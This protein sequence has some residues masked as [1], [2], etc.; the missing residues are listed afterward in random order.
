VSVIIRTCN[1]P[2]LLKRAVDSAMAQV[3]ANIEIVVIDDGLYKA[4]QDFAQDATGAFPVQY[5]C[6]CQLGRSAAANLGL[7]RA[8]GDFVVFLDDDDEFYP[9]HLSVLMFHLMAHNTVVYTDCEMAVE[10]YHVATD[11]LETRERFVRFSQDFNKGLL[12]IRN[13]IPLMCACFPKALLLDLG[14]FDE[15]LDLFEDWDLMIRASDRTDF[16]HVPEVTARYRLWDRQQ[17]RS[18]VGV[19]DTESAYCQVAA[20]N[21]KILTPKDLF[22]TYQFT[23]EIF[24]LRAEV[25]RGSRKNEEILQLSERIRTLENQVSAL[26]EDIARFKTENRR[27]LLEGDELKAFNR[28]YIDEN[29]RKEAHI[30]KIS[31]MLQAASTP[32]R[33]G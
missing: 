11:Q 22:E 5:I 27:L 7:A 14:G 15:S 1:R 32:S 9:S 20:K 12:R 4:S 33:A 6:A 23:E 29:M 28:L 25:H 8:S 19:Q 24:N 30:V 21:L 13:Y 17:Q 10:T 3:Y 31:K 16:F 2:F 26:K 18:R